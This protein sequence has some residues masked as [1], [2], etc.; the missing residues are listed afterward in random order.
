MGSESAWAFGYSPA[1]PAGTYPGSA[2]GMPGGNGPAAF[3]EI[4]SGI[5]VAVMRNRCSIGDFTAATRADRLV[6]DALD[7]EGARDE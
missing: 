4:D 6:T 2:F 7:Q 1:R 3:A 5:A